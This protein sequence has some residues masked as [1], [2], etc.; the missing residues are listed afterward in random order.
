M[1]WHVL[2]SE[3]NILNRGEGAVG[4]Q[5][6]HPACPH[7]HIVSL[8]EQFSINR[9]VK[10]VER[11][12]VNGVKELPEFLKA[13]LEGKDVLVVIHN[14]PFD[15]S[16]FIKEWPEEMMQALPH[17]YVW[18]TMQVEFLLEGGDK[19]MP[20]LDWCA[21]NRGLPLK[22]DRIKQYWKAG[23]DTSLIPKQELLE[24]MWQDV[25][26]TRQI[27]LDQWNTVSQS[28]KLLELVRVKMDDK[29]L[30]TFMQIYGMHF[31]LTKAAELLAEVDKQMQEV[32]TTIMEEGSKH[33]AEDFTFNPAS[34]DQVSAL[35]FGGTYTVDRREPVLGEDGNPVLFKSGA[36]KGQPKDRKVEVVLETK[37]LGLPS[38]NIPTIKGGKG[39]STSDEH[40][41][42]LDHPLASLLLQ[43]RG[44]KKDAE[45]YY[46]GYASLTWPDGCIRPDQ[47]HETVVTGRLSCARPN[48]ANVS[49]GED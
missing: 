4:E 13:A 25:D 40:L 46:R 44:L 49:K 1:K 34:P 33:F 20:S 29:L 32:Y 42:K 8:G 15:F 45:T 30:T 14:V 7:N 18:D 10:Y 3:T 47:Q 6:G 12:D 17:I 27:F 35:M 28:P 31:N 36:R 11:Y 24:Y 19:I 43:Y 5:Q 37:G 41:S 21:E 48:L 38:K 26:N 22:D 9:E 23:T 16:Y 39:F 2:D